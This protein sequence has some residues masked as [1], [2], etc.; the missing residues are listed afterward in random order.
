MYCAMKSSFITDI[1][2]VGSLSH[3]AHLERYAMH[4]RRTCDGPSVVLVERL[5]SFDPTCTT[6]QRAQLAARSALSGRTRERTSRQRLEKQKEQ[7]NKHIYHPLECIATLRLR[8][9]YANLVAAHTRRWLFLRSLPG[10][11]GAGR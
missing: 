2:R 1:P 9:L 11:V 6:L 7:K 8:S 4:A 10:P 3:N 5:H